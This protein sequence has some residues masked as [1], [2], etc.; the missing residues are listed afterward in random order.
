MAE[1]NTILLS[2]YPLIKIFLKTSALAGNKYIYLMNWY[3]TMV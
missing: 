3:F 2:N 1:T